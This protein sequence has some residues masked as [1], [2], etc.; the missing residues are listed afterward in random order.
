VKIALGIPDIDVEAKSIMPWA[1]T[2]RMAEKFP[3]GQ[4]FLAGDAAHPMPPWHRLDA[5]TGVA[6]VHNLAEARSSSPETSNYK[7]ACYT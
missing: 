2:V 6:D 7:I 1:A 5:N 4:M 3:H